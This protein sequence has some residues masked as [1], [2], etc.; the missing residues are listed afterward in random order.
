MQNGPVSGKLDRDL[1][2]L[3]VPERPL[4]RAGGKGTIQRKRSLAM[5]LDEIDR[6]YIEFAKKTL[7]ASSNPLSA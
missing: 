6:L 2:L 4:V 5:Y 3:T 1:V 7:G